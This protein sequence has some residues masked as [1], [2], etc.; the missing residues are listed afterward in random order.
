MAEKTAMYGNFLKVATQAM[1]AFGMKA[2]LLTKDYAP[3]QDTHGVYS[4]LTNELTSV[5]TNYPAGGVVVQ[6]LT[7]GYSAGKTPGGYATIYAFDLTYDDIIAPAIDICYVVFYLADTPK[8]LVGYLN[9]YEMNNYA[10]VNLNNQD[11]VITLSN[12]FVKLSLKGEE[13]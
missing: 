9:L 7:V 11:L 12:G 6:D 13:V 1:T 8:T 3:N 10:Y 4:D 5:G 2:C